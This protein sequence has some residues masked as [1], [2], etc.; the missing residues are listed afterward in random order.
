[1]FQFFLFYSIDDVF[2]DMLWF[3][4][5]RWFHDISVTLQVAVTYQVKTGKEKIGSISAHLNKTH[6][7]MIKRWLL[8]MFYE[9]PNVFSTVVIPRKYPQYIFVMNDILV[10]YQSLPV[11]QSFIFQGPLQV[12]ICIISTSRVS[13]LYFK[14]GVF[15][16]SFQFVS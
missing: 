4:S 2:S 9:E 15:L 16:T 10:E 3:L 6:F 5:R 11:T 1:M 8:Q 7:K 14:G 12:I 13:L